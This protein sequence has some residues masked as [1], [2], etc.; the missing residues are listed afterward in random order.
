MTDLPAQLSGT[1]TRYKGNGR[2]LGYPTANMHVQTDL[3]DGVYF[4]FADLG[5]K[6]HQPALIFI[7]VPTTLGDTERRVEAHVLDLLDIDYYDSPLQL[8]VAVYHRQNHTFA[9]ID[10]LLAV[11]HD[12]EAQARAWFKQQS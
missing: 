9:S 11:M 4:G 5:G 7:G 1:V 10:E 2:K 12:D 8:E 3:A 6:V